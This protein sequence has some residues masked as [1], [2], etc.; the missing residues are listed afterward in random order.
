MKK[1]IFFSLVL[2]M[3]AL[4]AGAQTSDN[5]WKKNLANL[6]VSKYPYTS[7]SAGQLVD[8]KEVYFRRIQ[9]Y[10]MP[11]VETQM[12][13]AAKYKAINDLREEEAARFLSLLKD[14][15]KVKEVSSF[16]EGRIPDG[17][18]GGRRR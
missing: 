7:G 6:L 12:G 1:S 10:Q 4:G 17:R 11:H 3:V 2:L 9:A 8:I 18:G 15:A 14:E 13:K 5:S 16:L